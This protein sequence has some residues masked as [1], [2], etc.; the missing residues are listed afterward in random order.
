[1]EHIVSQPVQPAFSDA[2]RRGRVANFILAKPALALAIIMAAVGTTGLLIWFGIQ[3]SFATDFS[4]YWRTANEPLTMAY[5]PRD[6][7]PFPYAPTML[8]WVSP[9]SVVPMWPAFA[10]W[11]CISV[12]VFMRTCRPYLSG[13]QI[14]L[15]LL[16]PLVVNG[17]ATGQVSVCLAAIL[18]WCVNTSNRIMAGLGLAFI[19]SIKPQLVIFAPLLLLLRRDWT[20]FFAAVLGF[21]GIVASTLAIFGFEPWFEWIASLNNFHRVLIEQNVL[22]VAAT[23]AGVAERWNLPPLPF[24][25]A[26]VLAGIWLVL[27]CKKAEPLET[28]AA[29][30]TASLLAAPYALTYDLAALVPFLVW[31][32][33]RGSLASA[34]AIG[35]PLNPAPLLLAVFD[36]NR[37]VRRP[38]PVG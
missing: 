2:T 9:L 34:V 20:A 5:A 26:G 7:L 23:P 24:L 13:R 14:W 12:F 36:L 6:E 10:F 22:A 3:G 16:N 19:A 4:V 33:F 11:V 8:L 18:L 15:A 28:S 27:R 32:I 30:A 31:M 25:V 38:R 21:T 17:L 1:V 35:G 37:S 29:V